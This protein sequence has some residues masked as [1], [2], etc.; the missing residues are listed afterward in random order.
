MKIHP[1]RIELVPRPD[2]RMSPSVLHGS[3]KLSENTG[4]LGHSYNNQGK[5]PQNSRKNLKVRLHPKRIGPFFLIFQYFFCKNM[6]LCMKNM[7]KPSKT[8]KKLK[9]KTQNSR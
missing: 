1:K 3:A 9:E 5:K 8:K 4:F 7:K 2:V 6:M